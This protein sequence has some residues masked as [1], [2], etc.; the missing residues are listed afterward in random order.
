MRRL[1]RLFIFSLVSLAICFVIASVPSPSNLSLQ[2]LKQNR[3]LFAQLYHRAI[4][5]LELTD[6]RQEQL[7][8]LD[9]ELQDMPAFARAK[10]QA[11]MTRYAQWLRKL[12]ESQRQAIA[13]ATDSQQKLQIIKSIKEKQWLDVL[14]MHTRKQLAKLSEKDRASAI[15]RLHQEERI[16]NLQWEMIS[17]FGSELYFPRGEPTLR[18]N[19]LP[20]KLEDCSES[21]QVYVKD[22]LLP[23][24]HQSEKDILKKTEGQWP[25]FACTLVTLSDR[26]P[27]ALPS[28]NWKPTKLQDLPN[29]LQ[30]RLRSK[31]ASAFVAKQ[32]GKWPEYPTVVSKYLH[33]TRSPVWR[34]SLKGELAKLDFWPFQQQHLS[35]TAHA[36]LT[37]KLLPL[38]TQEEASTLDGVE[39]KWPEYPVKLDELAKKYFLQFPW[40]NLPTTRFLGADRR[41]VWDSYRVDP[42]ILEPIWQNL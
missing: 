35:T 22:Y 26:H 28:E 16:W 11:V 39:G 20:A 14:P 2:E 33:N 12:P 6:Q 34:E 5:F 32:E 30:P 8:E 17:R 1:K 41:N 25:L 19:A 9:Q 27:M 36:F 4:E 21:V 18:Q 29:D 10:Y 23:M 15:Q 37:N 24:L 31:V 3:E 7:I 13:N 40:Q 42:R 38:L